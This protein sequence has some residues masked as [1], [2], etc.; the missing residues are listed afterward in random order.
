V[1]GRML[2]SLLYLDCLTGSATAAG[3][4][5]RS[6]TVYVFNIVRTCK[7]YHSSRL[8]ATDAGIFDNTVRSVV[9]PCG[10]LPSEIPAFR[11]HSPPR[12]VFKYLSCGATVSEPSY[13]SVCAVCGRDKTVTAVG[14]PLRDAEIY[15]YFWSSRLIPVTVSLWPQRR[16]TSVPCRYTAVSAI[17]SSKCS[18]RYE[19]RQD[20]YNEFAV[21]YS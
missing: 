3:S 6:Y 15:S 2:S 20:F 7:D 21:R 5:Y 17:W 11:L 13:R 18:N 14:K 8:Q 16:C 19:S 1:M 4:P 10:H 9:R 12:V